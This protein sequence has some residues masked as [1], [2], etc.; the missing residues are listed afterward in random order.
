MVQRGAWMGGQDVGGRTGKGG[1]ARWGRAGDVSL[2]DGSI[3]T[4]RSL[5]QAAAERQLSEHR[6]VALL[7]RV[8]AGQLPDLWSPL[9][10]RQEVLAG[11]A[12]GTT[13]GRATRV[14][15]LGVYLDQACSVPLL[16]IAEER[17]IAA[18]IELMRELAQTLTLL[19][20]AVRRVA[21]ALLDAAG[22][23][24][25]RPQTVVRAERLSPNKGEGNELLQAAVEHMAARLRQT[26][27]RGIGAFHENR[28]RSPRKSE[29]TVLVDLARHSPMPRVRVGAL[30]Q[31]FRRLA[32]TNTSRAAALHGDDDLTSV[33]ARVVTHIWTQHE[34]LVSAMCMANLRL[35]VAIAKA[36]DNRGVS[37]I[38][39]VQEG[40]L[41]LLRAIDKFDVSRGYRF[42]TCATWWIR[43]AIGRA[44][45]E[46]PR[47]VRLP[48][49]TM[50][51]LARVQGAV[52]DGEISSGQ[53]PGADALATVLGV[54]V[55]HIRGCTRP[56]AQPVLSL[57]ASRGGTDDFSI[58][59]TLAAPDTTPGAAQK[60]SR[61]LAAVIRTL[62][63][64]E[65]QV[66][67]QRFGLGGWPVR[68]LSEVGSEFEVTRERVR[69]LELSALRK[70][71]HP[72]RARRLTG[73]SDL[74]L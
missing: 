21:V 5:C 45:Q 74:R 32:G 39:L 3:P 65:Q 59:R 61:D 53:K 49:H 64:R 57:E 50:E 13:R 34:L 38:D 33:V 58:G 20:P 54:K 41:G 31:L 8:L 56:G 16:S 6:T 14:A 7:K 43:Q 51:L 70:L 42:S 15:E 66:L 29:L 12:G 4:M 44:T 35:V 24:R 60:L 30:I 11:P 62:T 2:A 71:R 23:G 17:C 18:G 9:A 67:R 36:Y 72:V 69:Q 55:S 27:P 25:V 22:Q 73:I 26:L 47:L 28:C 68:T 46:Q 52:V 1:A 40:N 19:C 10:E 48:L 37:M 63:V